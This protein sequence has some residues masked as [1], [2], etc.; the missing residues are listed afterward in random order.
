MTRVE[1]LWCG[2]KAIAFKKIGDNC[3]NDTATII[4]SVK[5]RNRWTIMSYLGI[6]EL[7]NKSIIN[8]S[9]YIIYTHA[10]IALSFQLFFPGYVRIWTSIHELYPTAEQNVCKL[11]SNVSI[12]QMCSRNSLSSFTKKIN[13]QNWLRKWILANS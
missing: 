8:L 13:Q 4:Q 12:R 3:G 5:W 7:I 2:K 11:W 1:K 9:I 6:S 10:L